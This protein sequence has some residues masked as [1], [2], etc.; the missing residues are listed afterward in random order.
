MKKHFVTGLATL[1]PL[2][3]TTIIVLWVVGF[4]TKPFMGLVEPLLQHFDLDK[5]IGFLNAREVLLYTSRFFVLIFLFVVT[6]LIGL[7]MEWYVLHRLIA[8]GDWIIHRIPFVGKV[9]KSS[10]EVITRVL[11]KEA[12]NFKKV[13][14]VPFPH[15]KSKALAFI[16]NDAAIKEGTVTVFL[17]GVPN[18]LMGFLLSFPQAQVIETD[19]AVDEA[20]R[21]MVSCGAL[22]PDST[23]IIRPT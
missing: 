18:P 3:L 12:T 16:T 21:F 20:L 10:Q 5:P 14:L 22:A 7:L 4:L 11:N 13:V 9:Y 2:L 1:L 17:P 19:I 8:L 15:Q 23:P 6:L